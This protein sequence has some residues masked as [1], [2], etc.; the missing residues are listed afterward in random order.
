MFPTGT[1]VWPS[2]CDTMQRRAGEGAQTELAA[3]TALFTFLQGSQ[4]TANQSRRGL[5]S[6]VDIGDSEQTG[7]VQPEGNSWSELSAFELVMCV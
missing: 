3:A 5:L 6:F 4:D 2:H 1:S 7:S